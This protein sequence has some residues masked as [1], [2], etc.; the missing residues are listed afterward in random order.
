MPQKG[1]ASI[2]WK[3]AIMA[4][5][6]LTV[7]LLISL[8]F[9]AFLPQ[10]VIDEKGVIL[11]FLTVIISVDV[12]STPL[13]FLLCRKL[14][15][16]EL[17]NQKL[18][19]GK[20]LMGIAICSGFCM[21]GASVGSFFNLIFN[22]LGS[23]KVSSDTAVAEIMINSSFGW[24]VI[25]VGILAPIFE[26]LIFRKILIDH[27]SK[28]GKTLAV[29]ASGLMF[30]LY[31]GNFAQFFFATMLGMFFG[32]IYVTTGKIRYSIIYHM[33]VNC[34]TSIVNISIISKMMN[35][36]GDFN[37]STINHMG[38]AE[39][40]AL[41]PIIIIALVWFGTIFLISV[42]GI[43]LFFVNL[44]K[45][46]VNDF[47]GAPRIGES[48]KIIFTNWGMWLFFAFCIFLFINSYCHI[49]S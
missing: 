25:T 36:L 44:R 31:H 7:E 5:V 47:E 42:A 28:Y 30:G 24:R 39:V 16:G 18:S 38:M 41:L 35:I 46:H 2:G 27:L 43:V 26:E 21:V 8:C 40:N 10:E 37:P 20:F 22:F 12:V 3:Y 11:S 49:L 34:S 6:R 29:I 33:I 15:K 9:T 23:G 13:I 45:M 14:P 19:F 32:Y 48:L 1:T 17:G 4:M